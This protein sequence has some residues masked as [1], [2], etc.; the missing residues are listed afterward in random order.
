MSN[1]YT[2]AAAIVDRLMAEDVS[3]KTAFYES[4]GPNQKPTKDDKQ[5][6]AIVS[7]VQAHKQQLLTVFLPLLIERRS[8]NNS[9]PMSSPATQR[10]VEYSWWRCTRP[11]GTTSRSA[12]SSR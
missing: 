3:V 1:V 5:I 9:S 4:L 10:S 11:F 7:N 6:F 2:Q 8:S 12:T